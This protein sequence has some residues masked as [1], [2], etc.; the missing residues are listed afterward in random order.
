M[1]TFNKT[2][3][4]TISNNLSRFISMLLIIFVGVCFV[5][6]VGGI[7]PKVENSINEYFN[8]KNVYD[9]D[10]KITNP[11]ATIDILECIK[12][13][14]HVMQYEPI[15]TYDT[16]YNDENLR[17][18]S[19]DIQNN[20]VNKLSLI[21]GR[22]PQSNNEVLCE[23]SNKTIK[24]RMI[25][26]K[27]SIF[28]QIYTVVGIVK[29]PTIFYNSGEKSYDNFEYLSTIVYFDSSLSNIYQTTDILIKL[30]KFTN[31]SYFS[32]NYIN[33]VKSE[34]SN[35]LSNID[36]NDYIALT[37][38]QTISFL[39]LN[40]IIDKIDVLAIIFP[41]FFIA[42]VSLVILTTQTR[43]IIEDRRIIGC[44]KSLGY[45]NKKIIARYLFFFTSCALGGIIL[46]LISGAYI[47]PNIIYPI[48]T[49]VFWL[50]EMTSKINIT[51]GFI[52]SVFMLIAIICVT[53]YVTLKDI[54]STPSTLFLPK[55][56][57]EGKKILL[58]RFTPLWS[59]LKFKYKSAFRNIFRYKG[60][61]FM[62][63]LSI[64]G[65]SALI[66]AGLGLYNVSQKPIIVD[67]V[68]YEIGDSIVAVSIA[69]IVFAIL[70][71]ILVIYNI[72]NTCIA[73]KSKEI[74]TLKVL[75]YKN[76]EVINYVYRE[77][78]TISLFGIIIGIPCGVLLLFYIFK[79]M[80]FGSISGIKPI[81]YFLTIVLVIIII[82]FVDI[83]LSLKIKRIDMN[84]S[85]KSNE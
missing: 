43:M 73:E 10:I 31:T 60:R 51:T 44:Y 35:M 67:G 14:D 24:E 77:I 17:M 70:L 11:D 20:D 47:L 29:N 52:S 5:T 12:N 8:N 50:P 34:V 46:G 72:T 61:L 83:I 39:T 78:M 58:E 30:N 19:L 74:A 2:V 40:N 6:G 57:K 16:N 62:I 9:L 56:P 76:I 66:I 1:K 59:I 82:L 13:S 33:D 25:G 15:F 68:A 65:V 63:L 27:I 26:E 69:I 21:D 84:D 4:K 36:S 23:K 79:S 64:I 48:F 71:G 28:N 53:L 49:N 54:N 38:E 18:Y 75:G 7:T 81:S 80:D 32:N 42:I 3:L 55:S 41:F 45:S 85:L 22:Y 37:L